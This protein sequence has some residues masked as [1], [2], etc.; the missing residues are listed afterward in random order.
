[1][2]RRGPFA[3]LALAAVLAGAFVLPGNAQSTPS[4]ALGNVLAEMRGL[5]DNDFL[6]LTNWA[7]SGAAAPF[8]TSSQPQATMT[9]ILN[10]AG[11]DRNAVLSWL[12]GNGRSAL[13]SRGAQDSDIGSREPGGR[14]TPTPTPGAWRNLPLAAT[15][16]NGNVQ[17]NINVIGGFAAAKRDGTAV[18]ACVSFANVAPQTATHV[19]FDFPLLDA[20][21]QEVGKLTLDRTGEFSSNVQIMSYATMNEWVSGSIGP[22]SRIDNCVQRQMGTAAIPILQ[23]RVAG[24]R[25]VR[26]TY[27][28]GSVWPSPAP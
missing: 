12:Q 13:Y 22:R 4:R 21:G 19:V 2:I 26:V 1:M 7:R 6:T 11:D 3:A 9:D 27:A 25:V 5:S 17:G 15:S 16:L 8:P 20:N 24:Y 10:L 18:I 14:V 28:D 23:A